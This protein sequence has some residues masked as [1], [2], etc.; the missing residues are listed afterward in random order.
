MVNNSCA[1]VLAVIV[2]LL[3][4]ESLCG[5]G[6]RVV[7]EHVQV[8]SLNFPRLKGNGLLEYVLNL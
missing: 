3:T 2:F 4:M 6:H 7:R 5:Q 8:C 1:A